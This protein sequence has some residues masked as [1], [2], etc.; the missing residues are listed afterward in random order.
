L[1]LALALLWSPAAG[2]SQAPAASGQPR[3]TVTRGER[4]IEVLQGTAGSDGARTVLA[5]R[6]CEPGVLTNLFYGPVAAYV[7]TS[8]DETRLESQI[9]IVRIPQAGKDG[10]ETVELK[11]GALQFDRP[12]CIESLDAS[13]ARSVRLWQG[14]TSISGS[15]FFLDRG[16]DVA[17]MAGPIELERSPS[18]SDREPVRA[19]AESMTYDL[20]REASTLIGQ[21]VVTSGERISQADRL[22]LDEEA[23]VAILLGS[24]ATSR[25]GSD[26]IRGSTL[27]YDLETDEVVAIGGIS[28]SFQVDIE[29]DSESE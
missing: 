9:A 22:E 1:W 15:R 14:R 23:G 18:Y 12:G 5:N 16:T 3:V 2:Q 29:L 21:V 13:N 7:Q 25:R 10:D 26:E 27:R 20:E 4:T 8:I 6:N 24:P 28:A 19:S 11:G 17:E